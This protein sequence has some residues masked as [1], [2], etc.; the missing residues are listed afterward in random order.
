MLITTR[1]ARAFLLKDVGMMID[2][3]PHVEQRKWVVVTF[4]TSLS[5][6]VEHPLVPI[7]GKGKALTSPHVRM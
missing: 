2:I 5:A 4:S 1:D 7:A 3:R 6:E